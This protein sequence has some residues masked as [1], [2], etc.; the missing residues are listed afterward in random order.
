MTHDIAV[1]PAHGPASRVP[2]GRRR[3]YGVLLI[4]LGATLVLN[5]VLGPLLTGVIDLPVAETVR[6]QLIGLELVSVVFVAPLCVVA[7]VLALRGH[8]AAGVLGFGPAAYTAYMFVQ[9]VVGPAYRTYNLAV[10][11][12]VA[13]FALGAAVAVL[14][15]SATD[16]ARLPTL[17][18]TRERWYGGLLAVLAVFVAARYAGAV[19]G[20]G[21]PIAA[22]F[23]E[24]P[25][26]YW[27][28]VLLDLGIVVPATAVSGVALIRGSRAAHTAL[29]AVLGWFALVPPSV[30]AMSLAMVVNDDRYASVGQTVML[31]VVSVLF[32]AAATWI[33]RPLL[34]RRPGSRRAR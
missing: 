27:S 8:P 28:I 1:A 30:A 19:T 16:T 22:E 3:G 20:V 14:T 9:Y 32:L 25:A 33:Y 17:T 13:V 26:F 15:W 24:S 7:G 11:F 4:V 12:H 2:S 5:S 21:S 29:Y 10:L 31:G 18:R 6:N 23:A 34:R